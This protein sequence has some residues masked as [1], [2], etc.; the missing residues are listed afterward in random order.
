MR[1]RDIAYQSW[2][3]HCNYRQIETLHRH[4]FFGISGTFLRKPKVIHFWVL[5]GLAQ[6]FLGPTPKTY[7]VIFDICLCSEIGVFSK[8]KSFWFSQK[9]TWFTKKKSFG[10]LKF[11]FV[12]N[13]SVNLNFDMRY[14]GNARS[15][16]HV[17]FSTCLCSGAL[18]YYKPLIHNCPRIYNT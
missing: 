1:S 14:L 8:L 13:Y 16:L 12:C 7:V 6:F 11:Q 4:K 9:G 5:G 2:V 18:S 3:L 15:D 17:P 10:N